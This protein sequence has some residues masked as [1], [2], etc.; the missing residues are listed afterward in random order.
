MSNSK[1][2]PFQRASSAFLSKREPKNSEIVSVL[3]VGLSY[4]A[5]NVL[6]YTRCMMQNCL[7]FRDSPIIPLR[8]SSHVYY[9]VESTNPQLLQGAAAAA[10][11]SKPKFHPHTE[12]GQ[13]L[14]VT[15]NITC[16]I[17]AKCLTTISIARKAI[18]TGP[19]IFRENR[20]TESSLCLLWGFSC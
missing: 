4:R 9:L 14:I 16:K 1:C 13:K 5:M 6:S 17:S 10:A 18:A 2:L 15:N 12:E 11:T 3:I 20:R 19:V 8:H 7:A